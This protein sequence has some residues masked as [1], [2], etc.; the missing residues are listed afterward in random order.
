[1]EWLLNFHMDFWI[2]REREREREREGYSFFCARAS[3]QRWI[4]VYLYSLLF[5]VHN[6]TLN[7]KLENGQR[8]GEHNACEIM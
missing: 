1:M 4:Y 7:D 3:T 2:H 6:E 5:F 8:R